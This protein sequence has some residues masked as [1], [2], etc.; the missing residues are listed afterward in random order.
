MNYDTNKN[1]PLRLAVLRRFTV[2]FST[3]DVYAAQL[4]F[5]R[6]TRL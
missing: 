5:G 2:F 6:K 1:V 3:Y 4:R